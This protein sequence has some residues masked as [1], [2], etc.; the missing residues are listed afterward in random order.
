MKKVW[1]EE[2]EQ[3]G[4]IITVAGTE[5]QIDCLTLNPL[6]FPH[7]VLMLKWHPEAVMGTTQLHPVKWMISLAPNGQVLVT[8]ESPGNRELY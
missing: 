5:I 7:P 6:R 8:L 4:K 2:V 1:F 3:F